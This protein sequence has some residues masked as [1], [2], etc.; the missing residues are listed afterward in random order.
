MQNDILSN[1]QRVIHLS[2]NV[3]RGCPHCIHRLDG[4][5]IDDAVNHLITT[6]KY[7]LLH[8]GTETE[9]DHDRNTYFHSTVAVLG[10]K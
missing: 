10:L 1:Y 6:H 4:G 8:V 2:T 9:L 5:S 3:S 7:S